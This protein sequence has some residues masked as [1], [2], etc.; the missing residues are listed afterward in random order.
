MPRWLRQWASSSPD[1]L[2]VTRS[3]QRVQ[4]Y[5]WVVSSPVFYNLRWAT[6]GVTCGGCGDRRGST[7]VWGQVTLV[8]EGARSA[9]LF[10]CTTTP[11]SG[12]RARAS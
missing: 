3:G 8:T 7:T 9:P 4:I 1:H 10:R 6:C 11:F 5:D 12:H 2:R